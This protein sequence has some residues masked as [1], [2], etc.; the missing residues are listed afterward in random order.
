MRN[1]QQT[2]I[3]LEEELKEIREEYK[4][5]FTKAMYHIYEEA[6]R[7]IDYRPTYFK[8]MLDQNGAYR[9][10]TQLIEKPTQSSGFDKLCLEKAYD[11]TVESLVVE[12]YPLLFTTSQVEQAKSA[13]LKYGYNAVI[14]DFPAKTKIEG[15][16]TL[17]EEP[18]TVIPE[19]VPVAGMQYKRNPAVIAAAKKRAMVRVSYVKNQPL[20]FLMMENHTS[21]CII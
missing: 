11:L 12:R 2:Y 15:E 10:A 21:L 19:K 4:S 1:S 14:G 17:P 7:R 3:H 20:L 8:S 9:T 5:E 6:N 18:R 13:L 16:K